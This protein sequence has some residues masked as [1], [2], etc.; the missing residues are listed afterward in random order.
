MPVDV[1]YFVY[2]VSYYYFCAIYLNLDIHHSG[3][4]MTS[5]FDL[6]LKCSG[7]WQFFGDVAVCAKF[8]WGIAVFRTPQC[9]PQTSNKGKIIEAST[10]KV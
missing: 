3:F 8:V 10:L 1:T 4:G 9:F 5:G 2:V 7:I 6:V